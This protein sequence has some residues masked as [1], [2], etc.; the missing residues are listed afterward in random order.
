MRTPIPENQAIEACRALFGEETRL[1]REFLRYLQ[2]GG[3][4][5]A[6]RRLAKQTHPDLH[7]AD[8]PATREQRAAAFRN[9]LRAYELLNAFLQQRQTS[10]LRPAP[11]ARQA[12]TPPAEPEPAPGQRRNA[13]F[14]S[15]P[16]PGRPLQIGIFLY[17][18]G[19]IPYHAL[20]EALVWQRRQRPPIGS[21]ACRWGWLDEDAVR[22]VLA[23][24]PL[25]GRFG[26]RAVQ[27]GLLRSQQVQTLLSFQRSRQQK[28]GRY[29]VEQGYLS[30]LELDR[31]VAE[32]QAHNWQFRSTA[33]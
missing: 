19:H 33:G 27:L 21:L 26:E 20:I 23:T 32:L 28:L 30:P 25:V 5:S 22:S 18:R 14:Y 17:Y 8:D 24:R 1:T 12:P 9:I 15:G 7:P 2:P 31:L 11:T 29:F 6:F 10:P 16:L 13:H 3:A 4:K